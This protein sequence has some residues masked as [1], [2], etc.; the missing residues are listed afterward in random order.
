MIIGLYI[1]SEVGFEDGIKD[2]LSLGIL[3]GN[4]VGLGDGDQDGLILGLLVVLRIVLGVTSENLYWIS[5]EYF[6]PTCTG[7]YVTDVLATHKCGVKISTVIVDSV[8]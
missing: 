7:Y 3:L 1:G 8:K 2:R 6:F 5:F 4:G